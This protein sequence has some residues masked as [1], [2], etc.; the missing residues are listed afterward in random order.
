M[1]RGEPLRGLMR[2]HRVDLE[3]QKGDKQ[4]EDH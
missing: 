1:S 2:T 3:R 4:W